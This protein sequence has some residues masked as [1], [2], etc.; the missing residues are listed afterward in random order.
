M[1]RDG[2]ESLLEKFC[3][4]QSISSLKDYYIVISIPS[5]IDKKYIGTVSETFFDKFKVKNV[6]LYEEPQADL[7]SFGLISGLLMHSSHT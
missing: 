3:K 1:D 5:L 4:E 2:L 7:I 6:A